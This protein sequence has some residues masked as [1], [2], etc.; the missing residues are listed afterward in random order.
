MGVSGRK[1]FVNSGGTTGPIRTRDGS[2]DAPERRND[3][4]GD[5]VALRATCR[6]VN[7]S[8]NVVLGLQPK[9]EVAGSPNFQVRSEL[10]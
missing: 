7:P 1:G 5:H 9:R 8:K 2:F 6:R 3:D 10:V 4:G